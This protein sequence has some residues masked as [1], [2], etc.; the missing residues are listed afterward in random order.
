MLHQLERAAALVF[1]FCAVALVDEAGVVSPYRE[2]RY[3]GV[4]G[5]TD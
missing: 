3:E 1:L 5:Q 2:L 4:V